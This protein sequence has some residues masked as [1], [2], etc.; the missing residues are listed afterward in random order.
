[1]GYW[2]KRVDD[3]V[4]MGGQGGS[5]D[6]LPTEKKQQQQSVIPKLDLYL[7][8]TNNKPSILT[9][10][11]TQGIYDE[12]TREYE[13]IITIPYCLRLVRLYEM[14]FQ[15]YI[16]QLR[17]KSMLLLQQKW[18]LTRNEAMRWY[19]DTDTNH[20]NENDNDEDNTNSFMIPMLSIPLPTQ[21]ILNAVTTTF[22]T[23]SSSV[24]E[25]EEEGN[26]QTKLL[27]HL[28]QHL[29]LTLWN[30]YSIEIPIFIWQEHEEK[31]AAR[32]TSY[33]ILGVR[34]SFGR[35]VTIQDI[36]YLGDAILDIIQ[37]KMEIT[38]KQS[39]TNA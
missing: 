9:D 26:D 33:F 12:S 8:G 15:S 7:T 28:K 34:I 20:N 1:M 17:Y 13:N 32:T 21:S 31:E 19:G 18:N 4:V 30:I 27:K 11:L 37:Q 29:V 10:N 39:R 36:E 6:S 38:V 16:R 22:H 35:H 14:E 24:V 25:K 5:N 2:D 3:N 23:S